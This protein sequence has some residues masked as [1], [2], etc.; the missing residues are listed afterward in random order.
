[1]YQAKKLVLVSTTP[2][3]VTNGG[4]KV[5]LKGIPCIHYPFQ[6]QEGQEQVRSLLNSGSEVNAMNLALIQKLGLHIQK[7]NVG[8]QKI[9][10]S[11]FE[12]FGMVI[13]DF[14]IEDKVDKPR[15]F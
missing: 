14:Q 1:M 12:I 9:D 10:G 11:F 13:T 4:E 3:L 2:M 6:F 15:F 8:A 5:V 7:T